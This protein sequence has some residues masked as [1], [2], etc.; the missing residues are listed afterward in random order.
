MALLHPGIIAPL[1]VACTAPVHKY[2]VT[3]VPTSLR[4]KRFV[5]PYVAGLQAG[6]RKY[7]RGI[8]V[9]YVEQ[10]CIVAKYIYICKCLVQ[11]WNRLG[12]S[13]PDR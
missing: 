7:E 2:F 6:I 1:Q 4:R 11:R 12:F 8:L 10:S 3:G 13:R 9:G 5:Q